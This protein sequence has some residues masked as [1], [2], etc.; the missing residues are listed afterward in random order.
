[1]V[2]PVLSVL[3]SV[4]LSFP[5]CPCRGAKRDLQML[6]K[7]APRCHMVLSPMLETGLRLEEALMLNGGTRDVVLTSQPSLDLE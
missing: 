7:W 5:N 6:I 2:L 3:F 1:M 4:Q